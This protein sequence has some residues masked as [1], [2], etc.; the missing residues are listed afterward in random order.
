MLGIT[1]KA[2]YRS[3]GTYASP[4]W[5]ELTLFADVSVNPT[6]DEADTS[7][8]TSRVKTSLKTMLGVEITARMRKKMLNTQYT[9]MM[10]AVLS[11]DV[12]DFLILDGD[13]AVEGVRGWRFD[14]QVFQ[15]NEGQGLADAQFVELVIRPADSDNLPRPVLVGAAGALTYSVPGP[16]GETFA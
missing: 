1:A 8:R 13:R 14:G 4:T 9:A 16:N 12:V 5:T 10:N 2:Y 6:W 7:S 3:S 11:D 15:G